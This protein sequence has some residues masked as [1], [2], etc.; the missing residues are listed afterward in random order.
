MSG[1]AASLTYPA[2]KMPF[3]WTVCCYYGGPS[4]KRAQSDRSMRERRRVAVG[5][6]VSVLSFTQVKSDLTALSRRHC[7]DAA[8][9][10]Q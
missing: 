7:L 3:A 6:L 1:D 8:V 9:R 5:G 4:S 10:N 2:I